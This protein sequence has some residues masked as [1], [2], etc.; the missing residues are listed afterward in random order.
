MLQR[1]LSASVTVAGEKV[2][3]VGPGFV[4]L[5]GVTHTDSA[6][7]AMR[8]AEKICSLR[9]FEDQNGR[10]NLPLADTGGAILCVSQFTLYGDTRRGRRPS[11]DAA[12]R[13]EAALPLYDAFCKA[14]EASGISC[15][16]G[17]FGAHMV[18][19]LVNDGPVTLVI[20]SDDL[21]GPRRA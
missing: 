4:V 19:S 14:V 13:P 12:A 20:D 6:V 15:E 17:E 16:R 10:M 18:V 5:L 1:V 8:M 2:A 3:E 9:V 11:F 7:T 21:D